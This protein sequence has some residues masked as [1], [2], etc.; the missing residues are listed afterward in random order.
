M[1]GLLSACL[2]VTS[3]WP[4]HQYVLLPD[5]QTFRKDTHDKDPEYWTKSALDELHAALNMESTVGVA[6]NVILFLGDGMGIPTVTASRIFAGQVKGQS[7]EENSLSF[8]KFPHVALAKTYSVDKQTPDSAATGTAFLTGVKAN[9]N[10]LGVN[11]NAEYNKCESVEGNEVLSILRFSLQQG[12]SAG[13]I[14]TTRITH[15]TPAASYAHVTN[16]NWEGDSKMVGVTGGCKDIAE[17][18]VEDNPDIQVLLGGGRMFFTP[19]TAL[20]PDEGNNEAQ[21]EHGRRDER[22]LI[23]A[24]KNRMAANKQKYRYVTNLTDFNN[25]DPLE[26]DFLLGLFN[27]DHMQFEAER[28]QNPNKEPSLAAMTDKAIRILRKNPKG[29]FLFVE[30]GR[31]DHAH[32]VNRVALALSDTVAFSEAVSRADNL[33]NH[34]DTLIVTTADHSHTMMM[35][36]YPS[37]GNNIL[38]VVDTSLDDDNL[39]YTTLIYGNGRNVNYGGRRNLT[40]DVTTNVNYTSEAAVRHNIETH[41]GEDVGIYARGPMSHLFH[42]VHEQNYIAHVMMYASCVGPYAEDRQCARSLLSAPTGRP[43]KPCINTASSNHWNLILL[44]TVILE[45]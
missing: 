15:A 42:G 10:T 20:D 33:T 21:R 45:L 18:L 28:Q 31:I 24:W 44:I 25:V 40:N 23:D 1:E 29:Y 32:H 17:Q 38:G 13:V 12:K 5:S 43:Q 37:R 4:S 27:Q 14:T 22:N 6:H 9:S 19:N 34:R 35:A 30:G 7:G 39:T 8:D 3:V 41:G 16:R 2:L 36:G 26:T 11:G